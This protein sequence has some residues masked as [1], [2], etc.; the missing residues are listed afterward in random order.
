MEL[1]YV[2]T[3]W[4]ISSPFPDLQETYA[5]QGTPLLPPLDKPDARALVSRPSS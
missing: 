4:P 1:T 3:K 5:N 2:S